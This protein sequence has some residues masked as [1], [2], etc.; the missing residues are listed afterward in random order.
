MLKIYLT[1][2]MYNVQ[3]LYFV[4]VFATVGKNIRN[5][6]SGIILTV[7]TAY[8]CFVSPVIIL[9]NVTEIPGRKEA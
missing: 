6:S 3:W 5:Y 9:H 7:V 1:G 8:P 2:P 4:A